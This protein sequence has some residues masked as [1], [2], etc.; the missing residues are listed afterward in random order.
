MAVV[1]ADR[2]LGI[3]MLTALVAGNMIGSG[4]F[5]LPASLASIGSISLVSWFF[6]TTGAFMLGMVFVYLSRVLPQTGGPYAYAHAGFGQFIGFQTAYCYWI[7]LWIG[8]AAIVVA[9]VGYLQVF[10]PVLEGNIPLRLAIAIGTVWLL[11]LINAAG[12]REAGM[13]QL[14]TT[15]LKIIPLGLVAIF[16]WFFINPEH[17]FESVNVT[18]DPVMSDYSAISLAATLTLWA[19]IGLESAT[20]PADSVENP[21]KNIP[22]A[23]IFGISI[24]AVIYIAG[25]IAIIGII[26]NA[27]LQASTS[28]Y[29]DAA[30]VIL[31]HFNTVGFDSGGWGR[32]IIA[33]GAIISCFGCLNG[34]V[35][36]QAQVPMAAAKDHLFPKFFAKRNKRGVPV[37]GL[38]FTSML[39]TG[40]LFLTADEH[41]VKQFELI[42][43][44]AVLSS[45]IPYLYTAMSLLITRRRFK[46]QSVWQVVVAV[47]AGVYVMWAVFSAGQELLF[48]GCMIFFSSIPLYGLFLSKRA[49]ALKEVIEE[50]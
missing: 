4:V 7:Q 17:F 8:N 12:V 44:L 49:A 43:L 47:L 45:L 16:G 5:L 50:V 22:R 13:V 46:E 11:T 27:E 38:I 10:F 33:A 48:Y 1:K 31:G 28:P 24:A 26:P 3:W 41:L 30:A 14:V 42:I 25:S 36:L 29:A 2:K 15:V 21:R 34:W 9:M 19:F 20:V 18:H 32:W 6:T 35:L 40:L 37:Y 23:T 39:I